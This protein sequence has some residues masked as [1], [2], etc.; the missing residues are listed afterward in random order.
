MSSY[1][2]RKMIHIPNLQHKSTSLTLH[3]E[4]GNEKKPTLPAHRTGIITN[5][6]PLG[7]WQTLMGTLKASLG[8]ILLKK[9][10]H[11]WVAVPETQEHRVGALS[12]AKSFNSNVQSSERIVPRPYHAYKPVKDDSGI[13][14]TNQCTIFQ[15]IRVRIVH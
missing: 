1:Q 8:T 12:L 11:A 4:R 15:S 10:V 6:R 3:R 14:S 7:Q 5:V 2:H 13:H 9:T